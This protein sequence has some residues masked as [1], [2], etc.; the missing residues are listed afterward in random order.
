MDAADARAAAQNEIRRLQEQLDA[1]I[2]SSEQARREGLAAG[3]AEAAAEFGRIREQEAREVETLKNRILDLE[4]RLAQASEANQV[5]DRTPDLPEEEQEAESESPAARLVETC[6]GTRK[7]YTMKLNEPMALC[8]GGSFIMMARL[9]SM[10]YISIDGERK[11]INLGSSAYF[12]EAKCK[13]S[14]MALREAASEADIVL[15]CS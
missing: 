8:Q 9:T 1:E 2:S 3:R 10:A 14:L 12:P 5:P 11:A 15:D 4:R 6:I 7:L 13:V